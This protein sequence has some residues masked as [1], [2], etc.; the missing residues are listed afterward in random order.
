MDD[1]DNNF[2]IVDKSYD[3][4]RQFSKQKENHCDIEGKH[5]INIYLLEL[6]EPPNNEHFD[7]FML[8]EVELYKISSSNFDS[9]TCICNSNLYCCILVSI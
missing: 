1:D 3:P 8:V 2:C 6:I 5:E 7:I 9:K 4:F